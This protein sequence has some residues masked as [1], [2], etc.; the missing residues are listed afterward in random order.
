MKAPLSLM[1]SAVALSLLAAPAHAADWSDTAI[2]YRYGTDF[3]EPGIA[4]DVRKNILGLTHVSGF[5][6]GSNFFNVDIL[7]SDKADPANNS[8]AGAQE[9]YVVYA[10]QLHYSKITGNKIAFG[11]VTD[12]AW[13]TGFDLNSKD[14]AF[15]PRVRKLITGP[16]VK[17]GGALGWADLGV[18]LYK[19]KNHNGIV[20]KDVDFKPT[21]RIAAA[22]GLTF[23]AGP[24]PLKF[25]GFA[26]YT[27]KKGKDGFGNETD[28]E[29]WADAFLMVDVGKL[30]TGKKDTFLAGVGYEL[31]KG[32]FG[33][34]HG[35]TGSLT[36]TPM[37][38]A[39][40]HL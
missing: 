15:A 11:P 16:V 38:K 5:K 12:F 7:A 33:S 2:S 34:Q 26:N 8:T 9:V 29:T 27:G 28:P 24:V 31:V 13:Q 1:A 22:W 23:D 35:S 14:T 10:N 4:R 6:Y 3:S 20:G 25:N 32:K 36:R 37:I 39:E 30:T 18:L 19:E 40:W 17:F 21:Y